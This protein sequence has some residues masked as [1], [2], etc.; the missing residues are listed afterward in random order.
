MKKTKI[1]CTIGPSSENRETFSKM[2]DAGMDIVRLNFSHG[3][4]ADFA[5]T[6][7]MIKSVRDEKRLPLPILLDTKGPEFRIK[8]FK[9]GQITLNE[10]D[11]FTFTSEDIEGNQERVSVS[12]A[13]ICEDL[14]PGD[15]ILL[16]NGMI[17]FRVTEV[18]A[19]NVHCVV[20]IG[21]ILSNRKSMFF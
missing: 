21:G 4:H 19:P 20:E 12:Y 14:V 17:V 15:K 9:D 18:K 1:I 8:T 5:K 6:I 11:H 10:G 16:N 3:N 7:A 2:A 13:R